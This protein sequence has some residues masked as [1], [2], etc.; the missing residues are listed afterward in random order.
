MPKLLADEHTTSDELADVVTL[1]PAMT[2]QLLKVVNTAY[3]RANRRIERIDHAISFIGRRAFEDLILTS[4][5][6]T[7]MDKLANDQLDMRDFWRHSI[8]TALLSRRLSVHGYV[9]QGERLFIA[10]LLHDIGWLVLMQQAPELALAGLEQAG[11]SEAALYRWQREHLG[12]DHGLLG[13]KLCEHWQLPEWLQ[14]SLACHRQ[15]TLSDYFC[16]EAS[17]IHLANGIAS[18]T[19][20]L[21]GLASDTDSL[22]P[23]AWQQL[24]LHSDIIEQLE[25]EAQALMDSVCGALMPPSKSR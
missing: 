5:V 7:A 18:Q 15:P 17:V 19:H 1:D 22:L 25:S 10:G 9:M 13:A 3:Y 21:Y 2:T 24:N 6:V 20:P 8:Y 11:D 23:T 16:L 14:Q 4:A 12:Y